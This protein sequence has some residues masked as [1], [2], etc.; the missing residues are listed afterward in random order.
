MNPAFWPAVPRGMP[1]AVSLWPKAMKSTRVRL[2]RCAEGAFWALGIVGLV[3]WGISQ[4]GS[5]V[6]VRRDLQRFSESQPIAA[7]ASA[8]LAVLR[9]ARLGIEVPVLAG[10]DDRT[11]DRGLGHIEGTS[12]PG[13]DGNIGIA[14]HRDTH[15]R[16]LKDIAEGD[17]IEIATRQST[18]VYRVERTWIVD[19]DDVSVIAATS[20]GAVTLVTCYPFNYVGSAPQRF[21]VRALPTTRVASQVIAKSAQKWRE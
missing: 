4:V 21:I 18:D 11:L 2:V 10:T 16:A 13:H 7:Q 14:G 12:L 3:T 9:I 1:L 20:S 19:P 15:F 6:S 5:A 8:P 17:L